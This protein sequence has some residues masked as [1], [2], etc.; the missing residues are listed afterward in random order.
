M[1][2]TL[3]QGDR[4]FSVSEVISALEKGR[5]RIRDYMSE[6]QERGVGCSFKSGDQER[7][8]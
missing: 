8:H 2:L 5:N 6:G 3:W 7:L 1:E 4:Y